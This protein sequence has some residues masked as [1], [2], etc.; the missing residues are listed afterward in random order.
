MR[1]LIS[2]QIER[3]E[4]NLTDIIERINYLYAAGELSADDREYLINKAREKAVENVAIDAKKEILGLWATVQKLQRQVEGTKRD[5]W[6]EF[7]QPTGYSDA[8]LEGDRVTWNGEHYICLMDNCL[9]D[10][11][12]YPAGWRKEEVNK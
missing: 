3:G 7:K 6:P 9:C 11:D 2:G 5:G 12:T 4:F 8:Y 10:P 1:N